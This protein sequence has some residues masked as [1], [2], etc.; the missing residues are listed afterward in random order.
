MESLARMK[1]KLTQLKGP[2][3]PA[4]IPLLG[5][6]VGSRDEGRV[7]TEM[8]FKDLTSHSLMPAQWV[9]QAPLLTNLRAPEYS[10]R[11]WLVLKRLL[12]ML[13]GATARIL[14]TSDSL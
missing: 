3:V 12:N 11:I 2:Q 8:L 7:I 5:D 10:Y 13:L 4:A 14:K 6:A 1:S 9:P